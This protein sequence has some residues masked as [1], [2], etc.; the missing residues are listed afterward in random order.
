M[1]TPVMCIYLHC[2]ARLLV[3]LVRHL[4]K[5]SLSPS[6]AWT[7]GTSGLFGGGVREAITLPTLVRARSQP[8]HAPSPST[9]LPRNVILDMESCSV[10]RIPHDSWYCRF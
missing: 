9:A 5:S 7:W 2:F 6:I 10:F 4:T 3:G 1:H 8:T